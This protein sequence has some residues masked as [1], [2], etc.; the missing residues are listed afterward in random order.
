MTNILRWIFVAL[1][2]V[3]LISIARCAAMAQQTNRAETLAC[4]NETIIHP[5]RNATAGAWQFYENQRERINGCRML[6]AA[7]PAGSPAPAFVPERMR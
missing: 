4:A 1:I 6:I 7:W 3:A 5:G 2:F